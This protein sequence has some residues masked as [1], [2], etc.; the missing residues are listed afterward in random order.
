MT[1]LI[2]F[3]ASGAYSGFSPVAS[4]TAGTVVG[5]IVYLFMPYDDLSHYLLITLLLYLLGCWVSQQAEIIFGQKDSG[6]IVID[7]IVGYLISMFALPPGFSWIL[8]GFLLFRFFDVVKFPPAIQAE[9]L[10]GGIGVMT[11]DV[12]AGAYTCLVLH[13]VRFLFA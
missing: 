13:V 9:K 1:H 2:I 12:V 6:K 8:F 3:L 10:P 7:E 4:G 5:I 11:D